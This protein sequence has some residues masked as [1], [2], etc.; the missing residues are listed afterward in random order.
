[1]IIH[2]INAHYGNIPWQSPNVLATFLADLSIRSVMPQEAKMK[3]H[4]PLGLL[5]LQASFLIAFPSRFNGTDTVPVG[6]ESVIPRSD[7]EGLWTL[8]GDRGSNPNRRLK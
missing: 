8:G 3:V 1:M 6:L 7:L 2:N 4:V 5:G